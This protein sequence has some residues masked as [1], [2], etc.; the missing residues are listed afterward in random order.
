MSRVFLDS[1]A[2]VKLYV[3]EVGSDRVGTIV[4][5]E[6][7]IFISRL[8]IVEIVSALVRRAR[9]GDISTQEV[10]ATLDGLRDDCERDFAIVELE[11]AVLERAAS[12][13]RRWALRAADSIQLACA[14]IAFAGQPGRFVCADKE[15]NAAARLEVALVEDPSKTGAAGQ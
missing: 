15:L 6:G 3:E 1:S 12:L 5:D 10:E 13:A 9:A 2:L 7:E 11:R 4:A 8:A 14:M